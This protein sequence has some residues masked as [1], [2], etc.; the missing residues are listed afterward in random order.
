MAQFGAGYAMSCSSASQEPSPASAPAASTTLGRFRIGTAG[1]ASSHWAGPFYPPGA[2]QSETQLDHYQEHFDTVEINSTHYGTPTADTVRTWRARAGP[3]FEFCWK[4]HK[5]I[6]HG[7]R[8]D[9]ADA[10]AALSLLLERTAQLGERM[11]VLLVQ[12]PRTLQADVG[13]LQAFAAAVDAA[14]AGP[15]RRLAFEFRHPSWAADEAVVELLQRRGWTL[16]VHPNTTG[17]ATVGTSAGGREGCSEH[18]GLEP[19]PTVP[20]CE[21]AGWA[22]VRLHGDNDEH[23]YR[24]SEAELAAL[25]QA[26]HAWRR[27]GLEV[28]CFVLVRRAPQ[29]ALASVHM[30]MYM[31]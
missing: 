15:P 17:R 22:Y 21:G 28:H 1:W 30:Y 27:R 23:T 13:M 11:G 14:P 5:A 2:K 3:G 29:C 10:L 8:L 16:V 9:S 12:C 4:A 24:Y 25:A 7:G 6:T 26:L 18:Y 20:P 31:C 19:L